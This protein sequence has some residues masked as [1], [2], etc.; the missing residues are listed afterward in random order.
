MLRVYFSQTVL[1][2]SVGCGAISSL[3][4]LLEQLLLP[5]QGVWS[6][7]VFPEEAVAFFLSKIVGGIQK[8]HLGFGL[9]S[10]N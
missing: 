6:F 1:G 8:G 5:S 7:L 3:M 9:S 2:G 10:Q 4:E